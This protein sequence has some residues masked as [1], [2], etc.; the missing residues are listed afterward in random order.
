MT[1]KLKPWLILAVIFIA[2]V[3]SGAALTIALGPRFLHSGRPPGADTMQRHFMAQLTRELNLTPDQQA[4][5]EPIVQQAAKELHEVHVD[6]VQRVTHIIHFAN[7]Q[8]API[9]TPDQKTQLD[10]LIAEG[11]NSFSG[12]GKN[13][14]GGPGDMRF[15]GGAPDGAGPPQPPPGPPGSAF[16]NQ[17]LPQPPPP[18]PPGH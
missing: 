7:D 14:G 2:G 8:I 13:W 18:A 5:I 12:R 15:H 4:K 10:K 16:T 6:E 1:G 11:E 17:A 3:L 9:L